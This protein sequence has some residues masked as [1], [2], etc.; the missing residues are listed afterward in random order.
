[1]HSLEWYWCAFQVLVCQGKLLRASEISSIS[2]AQSWLVDE[3]AN[4]FWSMVP[5]SCALHSQSM[6]FDSCKRPQ[7]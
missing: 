3:E 4:C 5:V 1:M 6:E 2:E 7:P